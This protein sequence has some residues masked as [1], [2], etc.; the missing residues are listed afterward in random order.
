MSFSGPDSPPPDRPNVPE[1][2]ILPQS[3]NSKSGNAVDADYT[4]WRHAKSA[5]KKGLKAAEKERKANEKLRDAQRKVDLHFAA[6]EPWRLVVAYH[7]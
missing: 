1:P 4:D 7:P 2:D 5:T 6:D 3:P